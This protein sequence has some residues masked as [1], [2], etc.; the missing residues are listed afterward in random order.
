MSIETGV[1]LDRTYRPIYWHEPTGRNPGY[2][3]DSRTLWDVFWENRDRVWGFAHSHPGSGR[4]SYSHEDVTTFA[5]VEAAMGKSLHWPIIT[6]DQEF[7]AFWGGPGRH[8]YTLFRWES[9]RIVTAHAN[10]IAEL[11]RRSYEVPH[12]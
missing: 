2:L 8:D 11:R 5:A 3:P 9:W 7:F 4:T 12:G 6:A 1:L 10:W